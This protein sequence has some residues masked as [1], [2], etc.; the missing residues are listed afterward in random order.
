MNNTPQPRKKRTV[1]QTMR[2]MILAALILLPLGLYLALQTQNLILSAVLFAL[3]L[4]L[5]LVLV[6]F[7]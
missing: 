6:L 5:T 3:I 2:T 4:T 7:G 1:S